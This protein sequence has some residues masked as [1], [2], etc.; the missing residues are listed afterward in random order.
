MDGNIF[1]P[2]PPVSEVCETNT[3]YTGNNTATP[4][5]GFGGPSTGF[6]HGGETS[7]NL[8]NNPHNF[9]HVFVGGINDDQ[10]V[11][12]LMSDPG[13]AALDPVFY[14][15]HANIDRMWA[16][17]NDLG[18]SNSAEASWL[19]GPAAAGE[20]EFVMPMPDGSSWVYT[21]ADVN[22]LDQLDYTYDD[23]SVTV[24]APPAANLALRLTKLGASAA[25]VT[26]GVTMASPANAELVGARD[27]VLPIKTS[28]TRATVKLDTSVRKNVTASLTAA[29]AASPPDRVYL[30]LENV[31]GNIDA[32]TLKVSVNQQPA[33]TVSLFGLRRASV[34]D[35]QHGGTGLTFIL[36]ITDVV[37]NLFLN[38]ALDT[39]SLDVKIE[40]NHPV[41]DAAALTVGR[42]S[43]YR[44]GQ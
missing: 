16:G 39:D 44:Q 23:L 9:V 35:G 27:G 30:Q 19:D 22:S 20:R 7:G 32:Y 33:G 8:E 25:N 29:S 10:T 34:K 43:V 13:I 11:W 38:N 3:V 28:G 41:K 24:V 31:R 5:P 26:P 15:H 12:G 1:I 21:P 14:M 37:D 18:N 17:W 36:D 42:I 40:P 6:S 4:P 2:I